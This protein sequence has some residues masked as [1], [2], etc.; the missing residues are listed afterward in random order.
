[1][2]LPSISVFFPAHNEAG[3]IGGLTEKMRQVLIDCG[4]NDYEIII[5][6]DGSTDGTREIADDLAAKYPEVRA[7]H[8]EVNKG[9][10]GAVWTGILGCTKDYIFFT[11]GDAQFDVSE[12]KNF[13]PYMT[14][15]DALLG[16][17]IKRADPFHRKLFAFG[18]GKIVIGPFLGIWPKDLDC[19]FKMFRRNLFDGMRPDAGGAM[20]TAEI[21]AKLKKR[22]FKYK[23]IGVHHYPRKVGVQSGGSP[24]VV[25]RA[26]GELLK[27]RRRLR[28]Q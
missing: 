3:N 2:N 14:E 28:G 18:W 26:F 4:F 15:Y 27:L 19:A 12:I 1:M 9:Y 21:I 5:V 23:E 8:H 6:D 13:I 17:R 11:D 22:G 7:I 20:V 16:Y 24:K 10:G 25:F